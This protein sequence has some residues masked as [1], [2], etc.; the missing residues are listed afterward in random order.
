MQ[1]RLPSQLDPPVAFAHRGAR[2]HAP[3]NTLQSFVLA[4]RLGAT[5]LESDVW[6]TNDGVA[7]LDHD[8]I[9]RRGLRRIPISKIDRNDLPLHIPTLAELFAECGTNFQLSLDVKSAEA[10]GP[11]T[12]AIAATGTMPPNRVWL[13]DP[14]LDNL[15][16]RRDELSAFNLVHSTRLA[17]LSTS[18]ELHAAKLR[19]AGIDV[20]N[21]RYTDWNGGLVVL[22]HRF[23]VLAFSWDL[24][25]EHSLE[26][27]FR[28]GVD[29]VYSDHTDT[30]IDV[31]TREVGRPG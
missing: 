9:V 14:T 17:R 7:V 2:S 30:M 31:M 11:A 22:F 8:G 21:M 19:D 24:Q 20:M 16:E 13:C 27:A 25:Y 23:D 15:T 28:M 3:D 18:P 6:V 1:Q 10:Y 29:G 26:D 4:L 5:G 12:D